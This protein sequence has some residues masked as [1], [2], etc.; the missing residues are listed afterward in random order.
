MKPQTEPR[1][2]NRAATVME[3]FSNTG[4]YSMARRFAF[5]ALSAG[6]F[7]VI[8]AAPGWAG[9][10][11][12]VVPI[13]GNA[14]DIVLDEARGVLYIADF[15]ANRIEVMNTSDLTISRSINVNPQ[16]GSMA[17][18]PDGKYLVIG[19][20][21]NVAAGA[22]MVAIPQSNALTVLNLESN[23]RQ[24]FALGTSPLGIAFGS[25]GLALIVTTSTDS[26]TASGV[27]FLFDPASYWQDSPGSVCHVS[28]ANHHRIAGSLR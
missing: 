11:G 13:G 22:K 7:T 14:S 19:H 5:R 26:T 23:T 17:M 21:N 18:S 25:D 12:K 8:L 16:P 20:Y 24:T 2:A 10:Y 1:A 15:T 6:L 28:A 4:A 27:I 3:R 9:V